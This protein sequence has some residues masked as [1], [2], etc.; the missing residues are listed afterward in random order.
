MVLAA[1]DDMTFGML[2]H[3][4]LADVKQV[5]DVGEF[6]RWFLFGNFDA[7]T[8]DVGTIEFLMNLGV[9]SDSYIEDYT[10]NPRTLA[11]KDECKRRWS[12]K[13][14]GKGK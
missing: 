9:L 6:A 2:R 11:S 4:R 12:E 1:S 13:L 14:H 5:F 10:L 3:I 7:D 8:L